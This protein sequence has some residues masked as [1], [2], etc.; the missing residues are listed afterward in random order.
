[1][2]RVLGLKQFLQRTYNY[3]PDLPENIIHSFGRLTTN[4]MMTVWG[5]SGNGKSSLIMTF[6]KALM[7]HG[8]V[9]YVALEEG[10]EASMQLNIIRN[11][12]EAEHAG[13]IEFTDHEM[14]YDELIKKLKKKKSPRF[15]VID[16]VQYWDLT[17]DKYKKLKELFGKKKTFIFISHAKGKE[18]DGTMADKIRYD[19][20]IKARVEGFVVFVT[21]RLGGNNPFVIWEEGAKRYWGKNY[22]KAIQTIQIKHMEDNA[23]KKKSKKPKPQQNEDTPLHPVPILAEPGESL[24]GD[25]QVHG[26]SEGI[27]PELVAPLDASK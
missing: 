15:I 26:S 2:A 8:K 12:D 3:L 27:L 11:L 20:A 5:K 10:F 14:T 18:P 25:G 16:S 19:S 9:L 22:K 13:K 4:F 24:L 17:L 6:I 21:S 1:M 7:P 23:D